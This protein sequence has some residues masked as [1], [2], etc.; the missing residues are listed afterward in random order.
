MLEGGSY[1]PTLRT[2][3]DGLKRFCGIPTVPA[4]SDPLCSYAIRLY[5]NIFVCIGTKLV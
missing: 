5:A 4:L 2:E 1:S 3:Y